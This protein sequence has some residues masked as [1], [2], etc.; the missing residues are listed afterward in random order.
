ML[1][2]L[3]EQTPA[4]SLVRATQPFLENIMI[5]GQLYSPVAAPNSG[6]QAVSPMPSFPQ[7][8]LSNHLAH[9]VVWCQRVNI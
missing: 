3:E 6:Q 4:V 9:N 5:G 7:T 1:N 8:P 2:P